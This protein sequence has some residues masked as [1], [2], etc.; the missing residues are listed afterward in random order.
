V[1]VEHCSL[2]HNLTKQLS[3]HRHPALQAW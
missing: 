3:L 2:I 1:H